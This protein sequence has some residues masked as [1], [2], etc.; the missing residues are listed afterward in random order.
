MRK[1][2]GSG[3]YKTLPD[4][5]GGR[6]ERMKHLLVRKGEP[7]RATDGFPKQLSIGWADVRHTSEVVT[8]S[9]RIEASAQ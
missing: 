5:R 8:S 9:L 2:R 1:P 4:Y 6:S 3:A 7:S